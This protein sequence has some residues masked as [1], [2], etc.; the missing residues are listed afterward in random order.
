[1]DWNTTLTLH[2]LDRVTE[3]PQA[4]STRYFLR[5]VTTTVVSSVTTV[6]KSSCS[7]CCARVEDCRV[8]P[9]SYE[10]RE[11]EPS[12]SDDDIEGV[13]RPSTFTG[14]NFQLNQATGTVSV[15]VITWVGPFSNVPRRYRA[16]SN[17]CACTIWYIPSDLRG[18]QI[19]AN[20]QRQ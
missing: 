17:L 1:M 3:A 16:T 2:A 4:S 18:S 11:P 13:S 12:V 8:S 19:K 6:P 7:V 20:M 14:I 10:G 15:Q 5:V 9:S